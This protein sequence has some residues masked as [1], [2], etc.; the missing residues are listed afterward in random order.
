ML[1][2]IWGQH[3]G[4]AI[5]ALLMVGTSFG[6]GSSS[7]GDNDQPAGGKSGGGGS[8][9]GTG[10]SSSGPGSDVLLG[11][12]DN[13]SSYKPAEGDKCAGWFCG[14]SE[15]E[16]TAAVDPKAICGGNVPLL[17]KGS[18]VEKVG[19]CAR[20]LKAENF[21]ATNDVLR[22]LVRDC[23]YEDADIKAAVPENC[24]DCTINAAACAADNCLAQ[25]I[26][27][28]S[29]TCDTCRRT[30]KCDQSVFDCGGLPPPI[31]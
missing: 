2:H 26:G 1:E 28:D 6:C 20:R 13:C 16:L 22:P 14:V 9:S 7:S 25:C 21:T 23:V 19:V 8:S 4:L 17:C 12:G 27:G 24:L 15:A 18:V 11:T 10:G 5:A 30:A 31:K 29:A 3:R